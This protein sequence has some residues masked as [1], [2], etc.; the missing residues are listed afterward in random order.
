MFVRIK[1]A[2]LRTQME[3]GNCLSLSHATAPSG[4]PDAA[5]AHHGWHVHFLQPPVP[6]LPAEALLQLTPLSITEGSANPQAKGS[7]CNTLGMT[8]AK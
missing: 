4:S 6:L 2:H 5:K 7:I 8:L 1:D 3:T